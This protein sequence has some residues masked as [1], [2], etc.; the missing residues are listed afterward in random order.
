MTQSAE[1]YTELRKLMRE[2][3]VKRHDLALWTGRSDVCI[4]DRFSHG[5]W[6]LPEMYIIM[7][8]LHVP[9]R[10]MHLLFPQGGM[11]AGPLEDP[12]PT[13]EQE[14]LTAARK[15]FKEAAK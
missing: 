4:S 7:D 8:K 12:P 2:R 14:F 5:T 13:A 9:Y 11:W 1:G 10:K 3:G 6:T 15:L